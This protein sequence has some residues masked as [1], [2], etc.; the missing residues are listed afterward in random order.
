MKTDPYDGTRIDRRG[1]RRLEEDEEGEE[2]RDPLG[3]RKRRTDM[4]ESSVNRCNLCTR[5]L[6]MKSK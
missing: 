4:V 6:L 2:L 3:E 5:G 1:W